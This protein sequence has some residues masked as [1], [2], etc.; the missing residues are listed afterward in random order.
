MPVAVA[1]PLNSDDIRKLIGFANEHQITLVPRTAGTSLAGQVV[2]NGIIVDVSKYFTKILE[3]NKEE[4][5]VRVQPGVVLDELN[6][7]LDAYGL[8]FGPETSTSN[9]CMMGG[10]VGNNSCGSHSVIY[11]STR[12]H[13]LEVKALLS[14]GSDILINE[15]TTDEFSNK[16]EL[17]SLEG[18]IY[19]HLNE[20]LSNPQNQ[21]EI[22]AEF[23]D[24]ELRRRNNGYAIDLLLETEPFTKNKEK[25]NLCKLIAGSEGTLAFI[26]EIKL[27]LVPK[28]PKNKGVLCVHMNSVA[29]ALEANLIALGYN[30][31]AVE[32]MDN[33][34]LNCTKDNI[35]QR[36]NRFFVEGDPGAIM[37]VEFA[38]ETKE[39]IAQICD[40]LIEH[41]KKAGY[42]YHFPIL[43]GADVSKVWA[44]RKS[45]LGVL[46]NV[47]G[48]AK[49]VSLVEDTAVNPKKLPDYIRDFNQLLDKHNLSCVYHAHIG[50]GELHLRPVINIKT[51]EGVELFHTIGLETAKIVKK[52]RGSLSGEH[53]DGRLR[54]EFIPLMIGEH[55]YS[56]LKEI[57]QV[58]DPNQIFNANK[59]VF[60]PPM[61]TMLR[62]EPGKEEREIE[63]WFDFSKVQ[64]ILRAVEKCNGA[65][66]CRKS[67]IIGGVMC[68]SY[69]ATRDENASTRA[70]A[71]ILREFLTHSTKK[72]PFDHK[73]IYQVMDLCLSC[74]GCKSECPSNVDMAKL[75]AEF[76]QHWYDAHGVPL[77]TFFIAY[78]TRIN[79]VMSVFPGLYNWAITNSLLSK[80]IK[81]TI[82]FALEG[83]LPLL[84]KKTLNKWARQNIPSL[85]AALPNS[86]KKLVLFV[87][88][89]TNYNDAAIGIVAIKLLNKLGY[90]IIIQ[91]HNESGRT[92]LSK[93]LLRKAKSIAEQN[94]RLLKDK[95]SAEIPLVGIE[96]SCI[97]TFRD[98]YPDL[99]AASFKEDAKKLAANSFFIDEFLA[100]EA[101]AGKI[102]AELFT[103]NP[104]Q[105]KLH[106]HCQQKALISTECTRKILSLP[107]NYKVTEIKSGCCGMA[108]SFGYEK[109]HHGLSVKIGEMVLFPEVRSASADT[110]IAAPG[111][112]CRHHIK[113]GTGRIAKHPVELLFEALK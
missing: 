106:G 19:H 102:S 95:V 101:D 92:F 32:L 99:V 91:K 63:T 72:N 36:R 98:E 34:I 97:L 67:Q 70:R 15:L 4:H 14:D 18:K 56:L 77:R 109:E 7:V 83:S 82:G 12:D 40:Q 42:G 31:G 45:G 35:T 110:E 5:W 27:N 100:R 41:L 96:P 90:F 21:Q 11:G 49:P 112:S 60:T 37:I 74:K 73:E 1:R 8:F 68:P 24:P 93:G 84:A 51:K 55:N 79:K 103:D 13:L 47:E 58:W 108:G 89:F 22:R 87:D 52:Y 44:L 38:R 53:G 66:D 54:G 16:C 20:I 61:N 59:I 2:G 86:D 28:P 64:G 33:V 62:F 48:D 71:N 80:T 81:Q 57:K 25:F 105:I 75:K 3:I 69:M 85:N 76:L 17:N 88:E 30:P 9:R 107:K 26:T 46:A 78:V 50:S 39:E 104:L 113:D 29:E 10:M 65:A 43:Y 23:P 6:M 111:T 94:I